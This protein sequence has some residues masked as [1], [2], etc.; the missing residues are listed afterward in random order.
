MRNIVVVNRV[1]YTL[2]FYRYELH[3]RLVLNTHTYYTSHWRWHYLLLIYPEGEDSRPP[4]VGQL[5]KIQDQVSK[6]CLRKIV[7]LC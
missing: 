1:A 2:W 7:E 5:V 6:D 4:Y 3:K